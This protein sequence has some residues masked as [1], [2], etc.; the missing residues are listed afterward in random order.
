MRWNA[1]I[2]N[3]MRFPLDQFLSPWRLPSTRRIATKENPVDDITGVLD[4]HTTIG[5]GIRCC[6]RIG[7]STTEE[8]GIDYVTGIGNVNT[9]I[10]ISVAADVRWVI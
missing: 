9:T 8:Y 2:I 10:T 5:V 7:L 3:Q 6:F 4:V 1:L